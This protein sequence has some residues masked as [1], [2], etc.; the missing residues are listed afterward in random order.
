MSGL[1]ENI[2]GPDDVRALP[3]GRLPQLAAELRQFIVETVSRTG[4]HLAPNLGVIELTIALLRVFQPPEDRL[5]WDVGHQAYAYK[6]LTGR[7]DRFHTLRKA[8][9][10]S[11]FPRRDESPFDAYGVGHAGTALSAALGMAVARDMRG[12]REHVV[13]IVGDGALSCGTSYEALVNAAVATRRLILVINDN[14]MSISAN[15]GAMARYLN[16]LLTDPK[17]N[18]WKRSIEK[19]AKKR[20][21]LGRLRR[22]YFRVEEALKG[23]FLRSVI[24]EEMGFRYIGPVDGH[25]FT[26]LVS[27]LETARNSEEPIVLHLSTQKGKGFPF[28]EDE[29]EAWHGTGAFVA[30]TG[31]PAQSALAPRY[32]EVFGRAI[33]RLAQQDARVVAV[34]AA[35]ASGT[36][37]SLFSRLFPERFYDVGICEEHAVL[38]AAG[39]ACEGRRPVVAM[40]STFSQR[41][42]DYMIHDVCLQNLPVTLCL[43]RAGV[44][45]DDGPTHHGLFDIALFITVPNLVI[46][47]PGDE[48][49]LGHMLYT[50]LRRNSPCIIR[51][52]RG[53]GP[54]A[55]Q[56]EIFEEIPEGRAV[57]VKKGD[58]AVIWALGDFLPIA[59]EAAEF[60][61]AD[62][63]DV[64]VVNPRYIKPIDRDLLASQ[65]R[66]ARIVAS[67]ENGV[68]RGGFGAIIGAEL[69]AMGYK[70]CFM[71]FGWPDEFVPQGTP[72]ELRSKYGLDATRVAEAIRKTLRQTA[73]NKATGI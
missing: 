73:G 7:R 15:V 16:R 69:L 13:A 28:A 70:G 38:F 63:I 36:G 48:N 1:L 43:D 50:A 29:P 10:I 25:D 26:A 14:K 3:A 11:G 59:R 23:L 2:N 19:F 49:E 62:G 54:G 56:A 66:K 9:G 61:R 4:G 21:R 32:S 64:G 45:G 60:L 17:Y 6:I 18:R 31:K 39:L 53:A 5:L 33:E 71:P 20:L 30:T 34:T 55:T 27:A 12:G 47:Q 58:D 22:F 35:M 41:V 46:M 42:V 65:A 57:V 51:Y 40:Y 37:L 68:V 67:L 24:M 72:A 44:V 52:P 8:D